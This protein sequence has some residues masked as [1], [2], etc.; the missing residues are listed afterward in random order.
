MEAPMINW[1]TAFVIAVTRISGSVL[2]NKPSE[3]AFGGGDG[4]FGSGGETWVWQSSGDKLRWCTLS[5]Y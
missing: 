3:A 2:I 5:G 4:S 1:P